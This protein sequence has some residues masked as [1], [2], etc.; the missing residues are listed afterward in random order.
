MQIDFSVTWKRQHCVLWLE[1]ART[2][3][4]TKS[5]IWDA[6]VPDNE[7]A[8]LLNARAA[9][10]SASPDEQASNDGVATAQEAATSKRRL[11]VISEGLMECLDIELCAVMTPGPAVSVCSSPYTPGTR[12]S[13]AFET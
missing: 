9:L 5:C 11:G 13:G 10:C 8:G 1:G 3:W 12:R 4:R 6:A 2:A 7:A